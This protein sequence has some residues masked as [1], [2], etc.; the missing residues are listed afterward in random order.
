MTGFSA[1]IIIGPFI[2]GVLGYFNWRFPMIF[3]CLFTIVSVLLTKT[4]LVESMPKERI[5][6]LKIQKRLLEE[7]Q[8]EIKGIL[9]KEVGLRFVELFILSLISMIF[10][11]SFSLVLFSRFTANPLMIGGLMAFTGT[12]ILIYGLFFMKKLIMR[13]GERKMFFLGMGVFIPLFLIYPFINEFWMFFVLM[14][15]YG[16]SSAS[17]SPLISSNLTKA[18]GPDKQGQLGGWTTYISA[19]SQTI[20]PLI[21]TMFLYIGSGFTGIFILALNNVILGFILF[22]IV[23]FDIKRH[24][25]L[26]SYEKIR[27]K[28]RA[29]QKRKKKAAKQKKKAEKK[30]EFQF[31]DKEVA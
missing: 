10:S 31:G 18:V 12:F 13:L 2:G 20:S 6:D 27:K 5:E 29:I 28:R 17:I 3:A 4:L 23:F 26:Y 15:P 8:V 16:F 24:P 22:A 1:S 14:I 25:Y 7:S 19:I 9:S 30:G 21:A 11:T